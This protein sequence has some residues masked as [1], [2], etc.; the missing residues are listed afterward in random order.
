MM[1]VEESDSEARQNAALVVSVSDAKVAES[2]EQNRAE[3]RLMKL[4]RR[5]NEMSRGCDGRPEL[6]LAA[7]ELKLGR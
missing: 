1:S 7:L 3:R 6:A 5:L 4:V 2:V